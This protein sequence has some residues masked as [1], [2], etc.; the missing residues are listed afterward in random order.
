MTDLT[1]RDIDDYVTKEWQRR[2]GALVKVA[3]YIH[4]KDRGRL[5]LETIIELESALKP[6]LRSNKL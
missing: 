2:V 6:F 5:D 3:L 4:D 1:Q